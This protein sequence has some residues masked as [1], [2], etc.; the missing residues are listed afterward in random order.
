MFSICLFRCLN[1]LYRLSARFF[2]RFGCVLDFFGPRI[3]HK[4]FQF[5][6]EV[7]GNVPV[8]RH[9]LESVVL[10]VQEAINVV[11]VVMAWPLLVHPRVVIEKVRIDLAQ[12]PW[13]FSDRCLNRDERT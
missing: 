4:I 10:R 6:L 11:L 3:V 8:C 2:C 5:S 9:L 7:I 13:A 1:L 12:E